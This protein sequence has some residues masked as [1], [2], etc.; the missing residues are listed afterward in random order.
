LMHDKRCWYGREVQALELRENLF[1]RC[2]RRY[3]LVL[4][5]G[6]QERQVS[7]EKCGLSSDE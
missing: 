1:G 5:D 2:C 6:V 7:V 3:R 4:I